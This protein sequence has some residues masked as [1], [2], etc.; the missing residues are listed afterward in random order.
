MDIFPFLQQSYYE[1]A[2][3][4]LVKCM[5]QQLTKQI[6]TVV[7]FLHEWMTYTQF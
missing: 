7:Y 4:I 3:T 5:D 2:F 6:L 1:R